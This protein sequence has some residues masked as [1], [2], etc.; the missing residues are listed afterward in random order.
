MDTKPGNTVADLIAGLSDKNAEKRREAAWMIGGKK[1]TDLEYPGVID[2]LI[3]ALAD[4]QRVVRQWAVWA[5]NQINRQND[6]RIT[7]ALIAL[8]KDQN[9]SENTFVEIL[10]GLQKCHDPNLTALVI[11]FIKSDNLKI[12]SGAAGVLGELKDPAAVEPLLI[13]LEKNREVGFIRALGKIGDVRAVEV[14]I[15]LLQETCDK[16]F[17]DRSTP[18]TIADA[19][20][21]IGDPRAIEPL[22]QALSGA[23]KAAVGVSHYNE[24]RINYI[25]ALKKLKA[26][27]AIE[28]IKNYIKDDQGPVSAAAI[29]TIEYLQT[30]SGKEDKDFTA[31]IKKRQLFLEKC[32]ELR[33]ITEKGN[34]DEI[35]SV[36][37]EKVSLAKGIVTTIS[38]IP[39]IFDDIK[40]LE[41]IGIPAVVPVLRTFGDSSMLQRW[42]IIDLKERTAPILIS[43]VIYDWIEGVISH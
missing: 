12:R 22:I 37:K 7:D 16:A 13:A 40:A 38:G 27:N 21:D 36:I 29:T 11:P 34:I 3:S 2:V 31:A 23:R 10:N 6:V 20:A 30:L 26:E 42:E 41:H 5:L 18:A 14:L 19:L 25:V 4:Q 15:R 35:I 28:T 17:L 24:P 8:L 32:N 9:N 43:K 1:V 33:S 39:D